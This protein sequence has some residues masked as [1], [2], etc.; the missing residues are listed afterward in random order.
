MSGEYD[1][2]NARL[3][4][5]K[6]R[7]LGEEDYERMLDRDPDALLGLLAETSYRPDV[8]AAV[9][10]TGGLPA[11]HL[12]LRWSLG[13]A[14]G[15]MRAFYRGRAGESVGRIVERQALENVMNLVRGVSGG[16]PTDAVLDLL[17]PVGDM[18]EGTL[19]EVLRQ[20]DLRAMVESLVA[21]GVPSRAVARAV[22]D[23]WSDYRRTGD[24]AILERAALRAW[25]RDLDR[26][27][28]PADP[29]E[30]L[31]RE[32]LL[33][34]VD[35]RNALSALRLRHRGGEDMVWSEARHLPGG[36]VPF[37]ALDSVVRAPSRDEARRLLLDAPGT[38]RWRDALDAWAAS[39][40]PRDLADALRREEIRRD[41]SLFWR[42][43]PLG[44]AVPL[45][46]ARARDNEVR[47]LRLV[48]WGA[49]ARLPPSEVRERL[50][51][52]W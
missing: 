15:E 12:A 28:D 29:E 13:R 33:A 16:A 34:V 18:D 8:E 17:V 20:G 37:A 3:R 21:W 46:Y 40:D 51:I 24:A 49:S 39:G 25:A 6:A 10:R 50:L 9:R 48:A 1:Y 27:L 4:A 11:L 47:N 30:S 52:P 23:A 31:L 44:V 32:S 41:V 38:E 5:R 7:L 14:L 22:L 35:R 36:R 42:G 19:R 43:D 2:G 26:R 45:A